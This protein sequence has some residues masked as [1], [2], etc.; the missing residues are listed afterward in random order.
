M[1]LDTRGKI[2]LV[3]VPMI[4]VNVFMVIIQAPAPYR[5]VHVIA[6]LCNT[7]WHAMIATWE[8]AGLPTSAPWFDR[9]SFHDQVNFLTIM[10]Y[11]IAFTFILIASTCLPSKERMKHTMTAASSDKHIVS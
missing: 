1:P 3:I 7:T 10:C 4:M 2:A 8:D 6:R 5:P 11:F 9:L